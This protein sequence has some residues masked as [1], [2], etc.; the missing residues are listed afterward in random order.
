MI[1]AS[2]KPIRQWHTRWTP[3]VYFVLGHW[4]GAL[5]LLAVARVVYGQL[6]TPSKPAP[7]APP[8]GGSV[9]KAAPEQPRVQG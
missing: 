4:S 7:A 5:I 3:V 6:A 2:L 1:Y 9:P 8:P